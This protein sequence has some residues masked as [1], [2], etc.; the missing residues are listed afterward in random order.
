MV[1]SFT[2]QICSLLYISLICIMYFFKER[3]KSIETTIYKYLII[4]AIIILL[5]DIISV[6]FIYHMDLYQALNLLFG[7]LFLMS[8]ILWQSILLVYIYVVSINDKENVS[9][10][11]QRSVIVS[12]IICFISCIIIIILPLN[13]SRGTDYVFSSGPAALF[14]YGMCAV[15]IILLASR[16]FIRFK[17]LKKKKYTPILLYILMIIIGALIQLNYPQFLVVSTVTTFITCLMYFTIENPDVKMI[18]KLNILKNQADKAN[19]AKSEF[20]SSMSHEIRTP[21]NAIVGFSES[22]KEESLSK[23]AMEEVDDI[24]SASSTLLEIVNGILDISKIEAN[25]I[26]IVDNEYD[27]SKVLKELVNLTKVKIGAKPI[28]L[29]VNI[30]KDLPQYLYGDQLRVKQV[31]L[32]LLTNAAKYTDSGVINFDVTSVI[33]NDSCRLI[34]SVKDTGRGI[35]KENID[36]LF[37]K[38]E[39]LDEEN[40][41][42][43]GTGLGLAITKKLV[44]MMGGKI[45]VKSEYQKGSDFIVAIDQKIVA[46]PTIKEENE[47]ALNK[48]LSTYKDKKILLVDDNNMNLKVAK[49]LLQIYEVQIDT[50]DNGNDTINKIKNNENYD[51]IL[52]DD[53]MPGKSGCETLKELKEIPNFKIPV[54]VL[55]ANAIEGMKEKYLDAGFDDY[56][57]KPIAKDELKRILAKFLN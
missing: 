28:D 9:T 8:L 42:I 18:E 33:A 39:R 1:G 29:K 30:A 34:I 10:N 38:F 45:V 47:I 49:R 31:I 22:L 4:S 3:I 51:L 19:M 40:S 27:I 16:I 17:Y 53:M 37:T 26:E 41:T 11:V 43:E 13:F 20:L 44:T 12:M 24:I 50:C 55:T 5:I 52:L 54:V 23:E 2:F 35:K 6:W 57:A 25:K 7:K 36:K 48:S 21:L 56:L 46:N 15:F 14:T 32:N